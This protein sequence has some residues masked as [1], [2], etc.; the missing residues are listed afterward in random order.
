MTKESDMLDDKSKRKRNDLE[1]S[2]S[3]SK[4]RYKELFDSS[5]IAYFY[6]SQHGI[7]QEVNSIASTLLG[8]DYKEL[9]K[10]NISS[11]FPRNGTS[12]DAGKLLVSEVMQ[13]KEIKDLEVQMIDSDGAKI[14]VSVTASLLKSKG[15]K[16]SIGR[17][18]VNIDRRKHAEVRAIA[19]RERSSLV[20]E[21]MT[22]DLNNVNQS[23]VFSLGLIEEMT[24]IPEAGRKLIRQTTHEVRK[25]ARMI[26]N[27]RAIINLGEKT[28]ELEWTDVHDIISQ[29]T[30]FVTEE[31]TCKKVIVN[32]NF[33]EGDII[34]EGHP[35]LQTVFF[36]MLLNSA[37]FDESPEVIVNVFA[38][39]TK[40]KDK[41]R[42]SLEDSGS[43]VPN[44]L[45]EHIFRRSGESETQ[46][47]GRGL[48]LTLVDRIIERLGGSVWVED[49]IENDHTKGARFV[50]MLQSWNEQKILECGRPTCM[51][52]Y[53]SDHCLFCEPTYEI[54]SGV[55][56]ELGVPLSVLEIVNV[57][58]PNSNVKED[59]L[60]MLP[61]TRICGTEITGFADVDDVRTAMMNLLM[62]AC[63]PY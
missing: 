30:N 59:E 38:E 29:A 61:T 42:I 37:Q 9:L 33:E 47:V 5:P 26:S 14:W 39:S 27:L 7:I 24:N 23:L 52:F 32:T 6:L 56:D 58:D 25:A 28:Y 4:R 17:L 15:L 50:L 21:V 53:K 45:K 13:G 10:R 44:S 18:A 55:M 40:G 62:K 35:D 22:H 51:T 43:G 8:Y 19:D 54:L 1:D 2:K 12:A 48:G 16:D 31:L 34:I 20:L 36:N 41:V 57:D 63:Y 60:P 46:I 11:I 3:A 49:R